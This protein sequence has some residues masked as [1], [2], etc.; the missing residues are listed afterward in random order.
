MLSRLL[1]KALVKL[2]IKDSE[3][4]A[5]AK[6]AVLLYPTIAFPPPPQGT[7]SICTRCLT[8]LSHFV[9]LFGNSNDYQ[10][11]VITHSSAI[12][13]LSH[14]VQMNHASLERTQLNA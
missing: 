12:R 4:Q 14:A 7:G 13:D 10:P 8:L 5:A 1:D 3:K 9:Y 11:L 2:D 6:A